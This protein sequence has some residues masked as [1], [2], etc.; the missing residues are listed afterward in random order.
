MASLGYENIEN[1]LGCEQ[2]GQNP[3]VFLHQY[4]PVFELVGKGILKDPGK[5]LKDFG[6]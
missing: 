3:G 6:L 5:V 1:F 2:I 4:R